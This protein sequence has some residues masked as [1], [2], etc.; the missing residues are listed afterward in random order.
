M[1]TELKGAMQSTALSVPRGEEERRRKER[2]AS[3]VSIVKNCQRMR[4]CGHQ[5]ENLFS[6]RRSKHRRASEQLGVSNSRSA[7]QRL[8]STSLFDRKASLTEWECIRS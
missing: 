4:P 1:M 7:V 3:L 6:A 2:C 5:I 8:R